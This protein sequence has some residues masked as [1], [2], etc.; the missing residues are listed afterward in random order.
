M[1]LGAF[2]QLC[3]D[4]LTNE[5]SWPFG[6]STVQKK[7]RLVLFTGS[8]SPVFELAGYYQVPYVVI[9]LRWTGATTRAFMV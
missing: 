5:A 1:Y 2:L 9:F 3:T 8:I 4:R 6:A 7:E